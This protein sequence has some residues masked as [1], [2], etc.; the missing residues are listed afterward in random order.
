MLA[1]ACMAGPLKLIVEDDQ[2]K[3]DLAI[4]KVSKLIDQDHVSVIVGGNNWVLALRTARIRGK[5]T[6]RVA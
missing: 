5:E 1:A 2:T 4:T 3:P 6:G